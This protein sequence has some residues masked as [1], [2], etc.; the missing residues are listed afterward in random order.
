MPLPVETTAW[1]NLSTGDTL[2][3]IAVEGSYVPNVAQAVPQLGQVRLWVAAPGNSA[4]VRWVL[5]DGTVASDTV[6]VQDIVPIL[7]M[8]GSSPAA[9]TAIGT[10]RLVVTGVVGT[11]HANIDGADLD[12]PRWHAMRLSR[13]S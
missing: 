8:Q 3:S 7:L 2:T 11:L 1:T 13:L 6:H 4:D 12:L 10:G 5:P 9:F